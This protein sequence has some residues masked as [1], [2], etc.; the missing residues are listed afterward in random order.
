MNLVVVV[1]NYALFKDTL[2]RDVKPMS[3]FSSRFEWK[4]VEVVRRAFSYHL[5]VAARSWKRSP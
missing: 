5:V 2:I 1:V 4:C 3:A